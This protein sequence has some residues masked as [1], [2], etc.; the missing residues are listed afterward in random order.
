[1][2]L[3]HLRYFVAVAEELHFTRAAERLGIK[4]PPLSLQIRQL[5]REMGTSLF[6]RETRGVKLTES[7]TRLLDEA[8]RILDQVQ[9]TKARVQ[10]RARGETGHIRLGF[11]GATYVHRLVP[12]LIRAYRERYPGVVLRPEQSNTA[13]L[14]AALQGGEIDVA[15]VRPPIIDGKGLALD[16]LIDEPM[17]IVLPK[18]HHHAGNRAMPLAALAEETLILFPRTIGP[19]LHDA[20]IAGCQRAGFSP[21]LGQEASQTVSII[22]MVAAGFGAAIVPQ[23]LKQIRAEGVVYLGIEGDAPRA[24]ISLAYRRDDLSTIVRNFVALARRTAR[25]VAQE[26]GNP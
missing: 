5:E 11:A 26:K 3:R 10:S 20:I 21:K 24:L 6:R 16:P 25:S 9:R 8:R 1:M 17:M 23:S 12:G 19:G 22:H 18:W 13:R 15:F 7:G 4:Q 2:E 14:V